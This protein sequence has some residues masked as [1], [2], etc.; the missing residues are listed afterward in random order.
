MINGI[1][2][3]Y[4][5]LLKYKGKLEVLPAL[6]IQTERICIALEWKAGC[7]TYSN[8]IELNPI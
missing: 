1:P 3:I 7:S 4:V 8:Y 6:S 2:S 5:I